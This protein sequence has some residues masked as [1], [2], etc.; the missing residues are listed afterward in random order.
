MN[1][2][3]SPIGFATEKKFELAKV[4][5][6]RTSVRE[7]IWALKIAYDEYKL[8]RFGK[9]TQEQMQ[10]MREDDDYTLTDIIK[11]NSIKDF[12]SF[13]RENVKWY[14]KDRN[15]QDIQNVNL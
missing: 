14:T 6:P 5:K 10:N 11:N 9:L 3:K 2:S 8:A 4:Q 1:S 15:L 7:Y 12:K 13:I